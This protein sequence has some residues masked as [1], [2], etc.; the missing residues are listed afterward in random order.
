M[1]RT[2]FRSQLWGEENAQVPVSATR[3]YPGKNSELKK[4][5]FSEYERTIWC[6]P[7]RSFEIYTNGE[8][9]LESR[10]AL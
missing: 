4:G 1:L 2:T 5:I 7:R 6:K 10:L 9:N 8:Q 3:W